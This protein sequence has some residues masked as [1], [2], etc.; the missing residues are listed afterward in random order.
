MHLARGDVRGY[1]RFQLDAQQLQA[2]L[3]AVDDPLQ[4]DSAVHPLARYVVDAN[5]AG[6]LKA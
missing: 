5:R 2:Q 3:M 6:V 4:P 1:V